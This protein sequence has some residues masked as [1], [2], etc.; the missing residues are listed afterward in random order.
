MKQCS[1]ISLYISPLSCLTEK[2]DLDYKNNKIYGDYANDIGLYLDDNI[3]KLCN[4]FQNTLNSKKKKNVTVNS[5]FVVV[6]F[7]WLKKICVIFYSYIN[8]SCTSL[9]DKC[10]SNIKT[11][12]EK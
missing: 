5:F 7:F 6:K 3:G 2:R 1:Y 10:I 4:V 11:P 8:I 12:I 9:A